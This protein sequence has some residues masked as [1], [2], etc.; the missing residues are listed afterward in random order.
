MKTKKVLSLLAAAALALSIRA[1]DSQ[2]AM[3]G[4]QEPPARCI[5]VASPRD[6]IVWYSHW[7]ARPQIEVCR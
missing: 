4:R 6:K 7:P 1:V 3:R 5:T 2:P